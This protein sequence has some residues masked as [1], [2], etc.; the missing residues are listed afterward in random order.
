MP[1]TGK[2]Q[3]GVFDCASDVFSSLHIALLDAF[4]GLHARLFIWCSFFPDDQAKD[5]H[6]KCFGDFNGG[7]NILSATFDGDSSGYRRK[8]AI[9]SRALLFVGPCLACDSRKTLGRD[10][11]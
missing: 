10:G 6:F 5:N 2:A 3:G 8:G 7:G 11:D 4:T 9:F 1:Q